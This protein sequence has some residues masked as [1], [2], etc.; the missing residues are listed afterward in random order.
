MKIEVFQPSLDI[1]VKP[2]PNTAILIPS[3]LAGSLWQR[4]EN[5]ALVESDLT[6]RARGVADMTGQTVFALQRLTSDDLKHRPKGAF[7]LPVSYSKT[8]YD[9]VVA[10]Y[11]SKVAEAL[12]TSTKATKLEVLGA[13]S[14]GTVALRLGRYSELPIE[15]VHVF[16]SMAMR[17]QSPVSAFGRWVAD[18][19]LR[20]AR[21][22]DLQRNHNSLPYPVKSETGA[23]VDMWMHRKIWT[24][25]MAYQDATA[26]AEDP[27]APKVHIYLPENSF[28]IGAIGDV[29]RIRNELLRARK[30]KPNQFTVETAPVLHSA[31]DDYGQL[32]RVLDGSI[33]YGYQD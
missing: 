16:D 24:S 4:D 27:N 22:P 23:L 20:E 28:T 7:G 9:D 21:R 14:G 8:E 12:E 15:A 1:Q 30:G 18:M 17:E 32:V 25:D 13:S 6:Q 2:D 31:T 10:T 5:G 26:L 11:S 33:K 29:L 3:I 19:L